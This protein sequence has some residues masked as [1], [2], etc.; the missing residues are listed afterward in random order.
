MTVACGPIRGGWVRAQDHATAASC[1]PA[2]SCCGSMAAKQCF[3]HTTA[4]SS[5]LHAA[6]MLHPTFCRH[7]AHA[8]LYRQPPLAVL[9]LQQHLE[10]VYR[11]R[12]CAAHS[13]RYACRLRGS[14][15]GRRRSA[16][17]TGWPSC[18]LHHTQRGLLG[19]ANSASCTNA[20]QRAAQTSGRVCQK[21]KQ[22]RSPPRRTSRKQQLERAVRVVKALLFFL[23]FFKI[24]LL[25]L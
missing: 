12:G 5:A 19:T 1:V 8:L 25:V 2:G 6:A 18:M 14:R 3:P 11:R 24:L 15:R 4:T 10:P 17:G 16:A 20:S 9:Y 21:V 23:L 7:L 13:A 22:R